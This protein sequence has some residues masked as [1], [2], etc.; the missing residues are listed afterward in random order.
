MYSDE[1]LG[2]IKVVCLTC[3]R[4]M[5]YDEAKNCC[6]N[7]KVVCKICGSKDGFSCCSKRKIRVILD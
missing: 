1:Y 6:E 4:E 7:N 5:T 2:N 3:N